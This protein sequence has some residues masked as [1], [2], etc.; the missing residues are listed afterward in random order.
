MISSVVPINSLLRRKSFSRICTSGAS[1]SSAYKRARLWTIFRISNIAFRM[2]RVCNMDKYL[3]T[4]VLH[5]VRS[6]VIPSRL[7]DSDPQFL[8][9]KL[10]AK[11][12]FYPYP[13]FAL[14]LLRVHLSQ[15]GAPICCIKQKLFGR[16][17]L[18]SL[19]LS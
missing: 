12:L 2:E 9:H 18:F 19:L 7:A 6:I 11:R 10:C 14:Q 16:N 17:F 1:R 13:R 15:H 5:H 4:N 8:R 3:V